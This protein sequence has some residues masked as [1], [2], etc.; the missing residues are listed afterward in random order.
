[1]SILERFA[2]DGGIAV[3]TGAGRGIGEG[4]AIGLAEAGCDVVVTAR[5][6][7]EIEALTDALHGTIERGEGYISAAL[8]ARFDANATFPRL[9]FEPIDQATYEEMIERVAIRGEGCVSFH[10]A[11]A[12]NDDDRE[13]STSAACTSAACIAA[14]DKVEREQPEPK[15]VRARDED[16][17][18]IGDD[19]STPLINEAWILED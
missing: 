16:G 12:D 2:L 7:N 18:F 10:K 11:L 8:L 3:V 15:R 9:P 4:I 5:R 17:R 1:M 13:L 19:P 14:A 6:E